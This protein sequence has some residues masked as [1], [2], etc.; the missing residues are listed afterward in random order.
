MKDHHRG[1][2]I[3][4]GQETIVGD[5]DERVDLLLE[6]LNPRFGLHRAASA[7]EPER[8]RHHAD[9][10]S[11]QR[12]GYLGH[13]RGA[14]GAGP[15]ALAGRDE[16]HV[17]PLEDL[18]DLLSVLLCRSPADFGVAPGSETPGKL[19]PDVE[20][21]ICVAHQ[22]RLGVGVDGDELDALQA[23]VD[24]TVHRVDASTA[25]PDDLDD[26]DSNT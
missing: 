15:T 24:N 8:P 3:G 10:Q 14:A 20:L 16:H 25:D 1:L 17:G 18:L 12:L 4:H 23:G 9:R 11:P 7:L 26:S 21:D 22:Q 5:H 6:A 13:H 19:A 2:V